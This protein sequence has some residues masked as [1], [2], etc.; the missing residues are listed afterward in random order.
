MYGRTRRYYESQ[1]RRESLGECLRKG[2]LILTVICII[3]VCVAMAWQTKA[4]QVVAAEAVTV[5]K[6]A[7]IDEKKIIDLA[8]TLDKG[9][10]FIV[11]AAADRAKEEAKRMIV[12]DPGH[13]GV[14]GG[15]VF[16]GV[17][18]K[19]INKEIAWLVVKKLRSK[20][21]QAVL[22]R[23][24]DDYIEKENRVEFA[25][26]QNALLYVSIHQN[27]YEAGSVSGI[28]TWYYEDDET[29]DS[30]RLAWLIQQ[31][32][33]RETGAVC[34]ELVADTELCVLNKSNMPSCLIETGFLSNRA[35]REKLCT[36][37]YR[38]KVAEGI[39]KGIELYLNEDVILAKSGI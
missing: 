20:G 25:N 15:C 2:L 21:Y 24:G 35:E 38:D 28:E 18:E 5:Q 27:S 16:D 3:V 29:G 9:Q 4:S 7:R 17:L 22:A 32:T 33:V 13:G 19:D 30:R 11:T 10:E 12:I 34:R 36:E 39:V 14:D 26:R 8:K 37:E 31:E 1:R 23:Q 6:T